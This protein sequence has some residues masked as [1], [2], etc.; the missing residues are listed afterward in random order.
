MLKKNIDRVGRYV[1]QVKTIYLAQVLKFEDE[2]TRATDVK[3]ARELTK[4]ESNSEFK[5]DFCRMKLSDCRSSLER[6]HFE[7]SRLWVTAPPECFG[8]IKQ[9]GDIIK[10]G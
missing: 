9:N 2:I 1:E 4:S 5:S 10:I 8:F 7:I 6:H 3:R